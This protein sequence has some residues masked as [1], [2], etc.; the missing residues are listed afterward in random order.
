[1][2]RREGRAAREVLRCCAP[3]GLWFGRGPT[4]PAGNRWPPCSKS[5]PP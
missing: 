3:A 5:R 1:M 2:G 4:R